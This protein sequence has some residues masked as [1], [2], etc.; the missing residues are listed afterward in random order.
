MILSTDP[1]PALL[2]IPDI[3]GFTRFVDETEIL[4]SRHI[5]EEL[6]ELLI[7][8]NSIGLHVS[9]IEGD[10]ILFYRE[11]PAPSLAELM[12]QVE[13]MYVDFHAHLKR[14][15]NQRIC[16]CGAC[17]TAHRLSLKFVIHYGEVAFNRVKQFSKLFGREVIL[18]HRLLKND[19]PQ[20]EYV[21]LTDELC[22]AVAGRHEI[23]LWAEPVILKTV[24]D[25]GEVSY[26]YLTMAPLAAR[27]PE[28]IVKDYA[29]PGRTENVLTLDKIIDAPLQLVFD[30]VADLSFRHVWQSGLKDSTDLNGKIT[31]HGSTHRCLING[32]DSDPFFV[33]HDFKKD[34]DSVTFTDTSLKDEISNVF[35]LQKLGPERTRLSIHTFMQKN[36]LKQWIFRWFIR[37]KLERL[38]EE[39][40]NQLNAYCWALVREGRFHES[41]VILE[42]MN[43]HT[44]FIGSR[45]S[46]YQPAEGCFMPANRCI[47]L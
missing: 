23:T 7:D 32:D 1:Q 25:L 15:E 43:S 9:E 38:G 27:I 30:V 26:R 28:P 47:T 2:F 29:L 37:R 12:A 4:H 33:S 18:T 5:I 10:A 42:P 34:G 21:L 16:Q 24:Y 14:Y 44:E 31:R 8:A 35:R 6:L 46:Q 41:R 45:H 40:L 20:N 17:S 13:H 39:S 11:G 22:D 3:S 36:A 19:V